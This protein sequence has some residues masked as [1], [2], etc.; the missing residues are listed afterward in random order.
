MDIMAHLNYVY[1]RSQDGQGIA[2]LKAFQVWKRFAT[3]RT[4]SHQ[5]ITK[6]PSS[7][8]LKKALEGKDSINMEVV[9]A[10]IDWDI[11]ILP[12]APPYPMDDLLLKPLR[13]YLHM[14]P[15][16]QNAFLWL[17]VSFDT[18]AIVIYDS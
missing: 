2:L 11:A 9:V 6:S 18:I 10:I 16:I 14:L 5:E 12:K 1:A 15:N 8:L 17:S 3:A 13:C 7:W 4:P